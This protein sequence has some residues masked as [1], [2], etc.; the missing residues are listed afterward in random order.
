MK[1]T[2]SEIV[3]LAETIPMVHN[4]ALVARLQALLGKMLEFYE[5]DLDTEPDQEKKDT[6][7]SKSR[8]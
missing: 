2:L 4:P 8:K 5:R 1:V 6:S 3:K 7:H